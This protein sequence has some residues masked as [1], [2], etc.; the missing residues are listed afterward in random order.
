MHQK[1][2]NEILNNKAFNRT[3]ERDE[4]VFGKQLDLNQLIIQ[5]VST[6]NLMKL[7]G[8]PEASFIPIA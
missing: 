8:K 2:K 4:A 1:G 3:S 6:P 5:L 7:Q